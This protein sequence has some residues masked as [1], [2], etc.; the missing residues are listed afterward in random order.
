MPGNVLHHERTWPLII[1]LKS[2]GDK[3]GASVRIRTEKK[4]GIDEERFILCKNCG[5]PVTTAKSIISVDGRH[6]H[7]FT[8]PSGIF[9]EIGCFSSAEGCIVMGDST[10]EHTWF[11]E[12]GWSFSHCSDCLIHL[13]WFY[14][15]GE[16]SFFGFILD[17]IADDSKMH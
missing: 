3:P 12:F 16:E 8:N 9:F 15:R 17:L 11:S 14:E 5:N 7:S 4:F 1:N 13:G 6:I 10:L 2:S